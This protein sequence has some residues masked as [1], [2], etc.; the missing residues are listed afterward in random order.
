MEKRFDGLMEVTADEV[1]SAMISSELYRINHHVCGFCGYMTAFIREDQRLFF[2]PGCHCIITGWRDVSW[3]DVADWI[4]MQS[5]L[6]I[7]QQLMTRCG[8]KEFVV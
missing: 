1:K 6:Q 2:D 4:N 7:Q 8:F 3:Q 5:N